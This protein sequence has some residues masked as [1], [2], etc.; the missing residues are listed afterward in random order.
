MTELRDSAIWAATCE[1]KA[2]VLRNL[3][4]PIVLGFVGRGLVLVAAG[5]VALAIAPPVVGVVL[6]VLGLVPLVAGPLVVRDVGHLMLEADGFTY[7]SFAGRAVTRAWGDCDTFRVARSRLPSGGHVV[8]STPDG[9][10]GG[11]FLPGAGGV[12]EE[13]LATLLNR[14]RERFSPPGDRPPAG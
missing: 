1:L 13:D 4:R 8:W 14:Y 2:Q 5:L 6:A 10:P 3:R 11:G 7:R 12:P 9:A